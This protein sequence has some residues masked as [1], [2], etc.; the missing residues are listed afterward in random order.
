MTEILVALAGVAVTVIYGVGRVFLRRLK[1]EE[2]RLA[3]LIKREEAA[4]LAA[5]LK[6]ATTTAVK[7][8]SQTLVSA[9]RG[10]G[11]SL[12][13]EVAEQARESTRQTIKKLLPKE[14][15]AQVRAEY[16]NEEAKV[17]EALDPLIEA[18]VHD[19]KKGER[20]ATPPKKETGT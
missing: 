5:E 1:L 6:E 14:I 12:A 19:L 16:G 11:G 18:T 3:N 13:P 2:L 7:S 8:T 17:N 15:L 4:A 9:K 20:P 10:E